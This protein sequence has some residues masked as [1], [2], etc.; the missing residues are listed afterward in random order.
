[1]TPAN[2]KRTKKLIVKFNVIYIFSASFEKFIYNFIIYDAQVGAALGHL[3][4]SFL[5]QG[6]STDRPWIEVHCG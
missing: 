6:Q 5:V 3:N 4:L 2:K 1:M